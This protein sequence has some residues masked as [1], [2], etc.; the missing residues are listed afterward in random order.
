MFMVGRVAVSAALLLGVASGSSAQTADE[1]VERHL[2]AMGGR[3]AI[4]KLASRTMTGTITVTIEAGDL[5]GPL[6][7]TS[8]L[9]NRSRTLIH[10]DLSAFGAGKMVYDERFDGDSG[11]LIDTM[12]GNR[13]ITGN[14]LH[15]L[16]NEAFPTPL[17]EYKR[18]GSSLTLAG[19][20]QLGDRE[21][22][23]LILTPKTGPAMKRYIDTASHLEIR[24]V[25]TMDSPAI[26]TFELTTDLQ[27]F[28]EVDGVQ[29]PFHIRGSSS[30]QNFTA[31]LTSVTHNA[32]VD[33]AV[34]S[35]PAP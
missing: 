3:A 21:A 16:R 26:G 33:A 25:T 20:E 22:F 29:V 30:A 6:E 7:V 12:Q 24:T 9:P 32:P 8:A 28:R 11:Y 13:D 34:F 19:R 4:G 27:D 1:I 10:L 15:N 18:L 2:A 35:R 14:Q 23:V 17:L 31:V 5:V